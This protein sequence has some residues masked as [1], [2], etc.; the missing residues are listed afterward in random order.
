MLDRTYG[1]C[2][3][4]HLVSTECCLLSKDPRDKETRK[5]VGAAGQAEPIY[6]S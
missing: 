1:V 4:R 6:T 2:V 3:E 5:A